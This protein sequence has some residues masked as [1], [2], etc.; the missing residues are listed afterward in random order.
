[1]TLIRAKNRGPAAVALLAALVC[2][3]VGACGSSSSGSSSSSS[4]AAHTTAEATPTTPASTTPASTTPTSTT[5][6]STA[7]TKTEPSKT[8]PNI[9]TRRQFDLVYEC[10]RHNGIGLPSLKDLKSL[11]KLKVNT[12]TPQYKTVLTKCRHEVLG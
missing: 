9:T 1:M 8:E 10:M 4:T 7:P 6:A 11:S 5:P 3:G 2:L 12:N